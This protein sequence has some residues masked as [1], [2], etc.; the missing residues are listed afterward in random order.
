V[1]G[2]TG[3]G[4]IP[5]S[6]GI[7]PHISEED[8]NPGNVLVLDPDQD[9]K[10]CRGQKEVFKINQDEWEACEANAACEAECIARCE[11]EPACVAM[12]I[13]KN[14]CAGCEVALNRDATNGAV[15]YKKVTKCGGEDLPI[16]SFCKFS[17]CPAP[18][19]VPTPMEPPSP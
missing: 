4:G 18:T 7:R 16:D 14:R 17:F 9:G 13:G 15:A 11:A 2:S 1:I 5:E 3:E 19:P 8:C 6:G 10:R 12:S